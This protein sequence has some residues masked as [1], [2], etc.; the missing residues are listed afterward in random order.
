MATVGLA[1]R[2][3][4]AGAFDGLWRLGTEGFVL[5]PGRVIVNM[6][7]VLTRSRIFIFLTLFPCHFALETHLAR[8]AKEPHWT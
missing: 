2:N 5:I 6:N 1:M 4:L 8:V 7:L 3:A